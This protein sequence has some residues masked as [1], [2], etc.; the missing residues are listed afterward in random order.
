LEPNALSPPCRHT[1]AARHPRSSCQAP[2]P[3]SAGPSTNSR[4]GPNFFVPRSCKAADRAGPGC[5]SRPECPHDRSFAAPGRP[6]Q[7]DVLDRPQP[8]TLLHAR[9]SP[10]HSSLRPLLVEQVLRHAFSLPGGAGA[11]ACQS[12][13]PPTLSHPCRTRIRAA[14]VRERSGRFRPTLSHP[15]RRASEP[16]T[17]ENDPGALACQSPSRKTSAPP[18]PLQV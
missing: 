5:P 3:A 9:P 10:A 8:P 15:C 12:L 1:P 7:A 11:F 4:G 16:R 6:H 14:N 13:Y 18:S 2:R 17:S